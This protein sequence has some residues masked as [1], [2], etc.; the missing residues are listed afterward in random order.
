[1]K[2]KTGYKKQA[3]GNMSNETFISMFMISVLII[4]FGITCMI[5]PNFYLP[6]NIL[7]LVMNYWFI[8]ILG[9]GVTFLLVT[10]NFDMSVGGVV[11]MT[12]V[13]AVYF[14]QEANVSENVLANGLGSPS[15]DGRFFYNNCGNDKDNHQQHRNLY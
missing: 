15:E 2:I 1:V 13:L 3:G 11:A 5:V 7:N 14:S 4:L 6:N 12:G 10:G 9:I 8:I